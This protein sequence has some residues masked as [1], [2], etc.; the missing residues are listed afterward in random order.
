MWSFVSEDAK[1]K[2]PKKAQGFSCRENLSQ[3]GVG[4]GGVGK[5]RGVT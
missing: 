1:E 2:V 3:A 4:G 5:Y